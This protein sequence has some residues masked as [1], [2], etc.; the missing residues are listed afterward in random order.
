MYGEKPPETTDVPQPPET[1]VQRIPVYTTPD[2]P[3]GYRIERTIGLC[4]GVAVRSRDIVNST[5]AGFRTIGGGEIPEFV[6]LA[7][8][9]RA[10]ALQRLEEHATQLG[11]NAVVGARFDSTSIAPASEIFAYGTAVVVVPMTD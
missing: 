2:A 8:M 11:A 6:H 10:E 9:T 3:V 4:W 1:R 7:E 5:V